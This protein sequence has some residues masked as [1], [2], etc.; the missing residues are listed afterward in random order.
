MKDKKLFRGPLIYVV[1]ILMI[2]L[3]ISMVGRPTDEIAKKERGYSE[4]M[5][6]VK[7]GEISAIQ[8]TANAKGL[9]LCRLRSVYFSIPAGPFRG[10]RKERFD[11][12]QYEHRL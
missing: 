2:I 5:Q 7:D 6:M 4:F 10:D 12:A 1:I 9:R 3:I 8:I 11:A